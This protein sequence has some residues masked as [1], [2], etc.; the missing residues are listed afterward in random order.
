MISGKMTEGEL[1]RD[2]THRLADRSISEEGVA[3]LSKMVFSSELEVLHYDVCKYGTCWE[4]KYPGTLAD[5]NLGKILE[6]V[7]GRVRGV[8]I[9]IDGI[10]NPDALRVRVAQEIR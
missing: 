4:F 7:P 8:D 3:A 6:R 5:L 9:L 2:I 10:V 1:M